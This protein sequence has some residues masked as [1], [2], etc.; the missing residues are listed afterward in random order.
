MSD[1]T[2]R[3]DK[4]LALEADLEDHESR[5]ERRLWAVR[6]W[7]ALLVLLVPWTVVTENWLVLAVGLLFW[8]IGGLSMFQRYTEASVRTARLRLDIQE[9]EE[10]ARRRPPQPPDEPGG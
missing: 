10:L 7:I 5:Q 4:L 8:M 2:A 9:A 1:R 3:P 6:A